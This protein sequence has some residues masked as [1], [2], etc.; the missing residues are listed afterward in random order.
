MGL[1]DPTFVAA[2]A[3]SANTAATATHAAVSGKTHVC[4]TIHTTFNAGTAAPTA[5]GIALVLRDG[6]SG[7]G[8]ILW[9]SQMSLPNIAG[10]SSPPVEVSGLAITGTPGNAMTL[11]FTGAGGA[12]TLETVAF[13]GFLC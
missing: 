5:A 13:S 4:Q 11:E 9:S 10:Q 7:T 1:L 6:P 8:S 12:N 3:P 2:N